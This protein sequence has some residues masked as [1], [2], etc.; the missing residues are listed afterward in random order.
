MVW[1]GDE[2][3]CGSVEE[4]RLGCGLVENVG[5]VVVRWRM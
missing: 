2:E 1:C 5:W 4:C 3:G